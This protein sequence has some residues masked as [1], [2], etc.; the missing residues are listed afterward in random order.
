MSIGKYLSG[1]FNAAGGRMHSNS[2][3]WPLRIPQLRRTTFKLSSFSSLP[4]MFSAAVAYP[5]IFQAVKLGDCKSDMY[6]TVEPAMNEL[7]NL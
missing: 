5:A 4:F 3:V 6:F 1:L 2:F 7:W